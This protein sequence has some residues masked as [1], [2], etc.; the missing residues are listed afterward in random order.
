MK[1][2]KCKAE[3]PNDKKLCFKCGASL[4]KTSKTVTPKGA[5]KL[6][7]F[8]SGENFGKRYQ[9]IELIKRDDMGRVYKA[10]DKKLNEMVALRMINPELSTEPWP[11]IAEELKRESLLGKDVTPESVTKLY[12]IGKVGKIKFMS[13]QYV[14]RES[15]KI[16]KKLIFSLSVAIVVLVGLVIFFAIRK[17]KPEAPLAIEAGKR[18]IA[19][20]YFENNTGDESLDHW[21]KA[22]SDLL[23][24]DL[25]QSKYIRVLSE[26]K[27]FNILSQL[28][29][30]ETREYPLEV[31][32]Q[33]AEKGKVEYILLGSYSRAGDFFRINI[34]IQEANT[35]EL[36]ASES[37]E[38]WGEE[39][40]F[41]MVDDLSRRIKANFELTQEQIAGDIDKEVGKITTSSPEAY[42][43]YS[44]GR[45]YH[46]NGDFQ[47]SI[48]YIERAVAIDPEFAMAYR[49]MAKTYEN[50]TYRAEHNKY[51]KKA[52][53]LADRVSD[54]ERYLIQADAYKQSEKT[55][56][57]AIEAYKKLLQ[58][59]PDDLIAN[60]NLGTLH[61]VLE[62]WDEAIERFEVCIHNKDE[63][64]L[65]Y[66]NQATSY[67]SKGLYDKAR[68]VLEY[69]LRNFSDNA[70]AHSLLADNYLCQ[71]KYDLAL[72]EVNKAISLN[73]DYYVHLEYIGDIYHMRGDLVEAENKYKDLLELKEPMAHLE[74][75]NRLGA[76]YLLQG[77]VKKSESQ[78][79][80]GIK[81]AKRIKEREWEAGFHSFL[82]YLYLKSGNPEKALDECNK[83]LRVAGET[84]F[85][86]LQRYALQYKALSFLE[87]NS[88]DKAEKTAEEL[89]G[90]IEQGM[91]SKL[92]RYYHHLMGMIEI[93]RKN[94]SPAV[95]YF[96]KALYLLPSQNLESWI[97]HNRHA[98]F[99]DSLASAYYQA[100]DLERAL[101]EYENIISLTMGR[102]FYGDIYAKSHYMLGKI[103]QQMDWKGKAIENYETFLNLW[104]DADPDIPELMDA[105]KQL[106]NL[107]SN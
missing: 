39:G 73:P 15:P 100:G 106:K 32:Q 28:N 81:Q 24:T 98:L 54:R 18:S 37:M 44:Q 38:A 95:E 40:V 75:R 70:Y 104:K 29:Q 63:D 94:F 65:S 10:M 42:K 61:I 96:K 1:C 86:A 66:T 14:E 91:N 43:Y 83:A 60:N 69:Y 22:L 90:M 58:L 36:I 6:L 87:L 52:L 74:G 46:I 103:Y 71:G 30:L 64:V 92:T 31:L 72:A 47:Q 8:T 55:F 48:Q 20:M 105:K 9:I 12:D 2:P 68:G 33:L 99:V 76:L 35:G 16:P 5:K 19:V 11:T 88:I 4:V 102:L 41:A 101:K 97:L 59:Y 21:R 56:Y 3:N 78:Y 107:Q 80:Q 26:E 85:L 53:E 45:R 49:S 17:M 50:M 25:S 89:K 79:K 82:A 84:E 51:I 23:I 77:K 62:Q 7:K 67:M 27:L 13:M 34:K 93:K 57:K